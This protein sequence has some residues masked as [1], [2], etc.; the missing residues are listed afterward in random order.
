MILPDCSPNLNRYSLRGGPNRRF[1]GEYAH[2][3]LW[4]KPEFDL[5]ELNWENGGPG[6]Y[7]SSLIASAS[8]ASQWLEAGASTP[9]RFDSRMRVLRRICYLYGVTELGRAEYQSR[10]RQSWGWQVGVAPLTLR[11]RRPNAMSGPW[12]GPGSSSCPTARD[13]SRQLFEARCNRRI[14]PMMSVTYPDRYGARGKSLRGSMTNG[15]GSI[16]APVTI[17]LI[18]TSRP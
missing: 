15:T 10:P 14:K 2:R 16:S 8:S 7:V 3:G 9:K 4:T 11:Q 6:R 17:Q 12:R 5:A 1:V 18:R 13:H